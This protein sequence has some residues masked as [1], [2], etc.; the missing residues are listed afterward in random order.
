MTSAPT[1][2]EHHMWGA[3]RSPS[4]AI[5]LPRVT[6]VEGERPA[7]LPSK[8]LSE[9]RRT[10]SPALQAIAPPG[11]GDDSPREA[12]RQGEASRARGA[13]VAVRGEGRRRPQQGRSG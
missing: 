11:G 4:E 3:R 12:M 8:A 7:R 6:A 2:G 9:T 13:S 10:A 5:T 1:D